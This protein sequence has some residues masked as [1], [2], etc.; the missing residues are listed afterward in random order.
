MITRY[1]LFCVLLYQSNSEDEFISLILKLINTTYLHLYREFLP[2][3]C[4]PDD[5]FLNYLLRMISVTY[6]CRMREI[7]TRFLTF[8]KW[9]W[10][11]ILAVWVRSWW[12]FSP[13]QSDPIYE[14]LSYHRD[15]D[16]N[17]HLIWVICDTDDEFLSNGR[18]L[19]DEFLPY[20]R[21]LDDEFLPYQSD[22]DD[23]FICIILSIDQYFEDQR[24]YYIQKCDCQWWKKLYNQHSDTAA[25][26]LTFQIL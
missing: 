19:D 4:D 24:H 5:V 7:L 26:G 14:L 10:W 6:S 12:R 1:T 22:L 23:E 16:H 21:D 25:R 11:R 17:T 3:Q 18:Y 20:Q 2:Y 8:L 15:L 9:Y 13:F